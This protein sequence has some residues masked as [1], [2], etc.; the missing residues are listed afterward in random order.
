MADDTLMQTSQFAANVGAD[1]A[2]YTAMQGQAVA[3]VAQIPSQMLE[4]AERV[5]GMKIRAAREEMLRREFW[6]KHA[7]MQAEYSLRGMR[8]QTE[9]MEAQTRQQMADLARDR[10]QVAQQFRLSDLPPVQQDGKWVRV[11]G[12]DQGSPVYTPMSKEEVE[13]NKHLLEAEKIRSETEKNRRAPA[14]RNGAGDQLQRLVNL[15]DSY[16]RERNPN[17]GAV[18]TGTQRRLDALDS[19]IDALRRGPELPEDLI[20][21]LR[22][23]FRRRNPDL[24]PVEAEQQFQRWFQSNRSR[25]RR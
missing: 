1:R 25:L 4:M 19:D 2:R 13:S 5:Q 3:P 8:A 24:G 18:P 7:M 6:E 20:D 9:L 11:S 23:E 21:S 12:F 16:M 17:T 14:E 15:R 22:S 10:E